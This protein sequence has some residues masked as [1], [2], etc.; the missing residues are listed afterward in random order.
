M[1]SHELALEAPTRVRPGVEAPLAPGLNGIRNW[2]SPPSRNHVKLNPMTEPQNHLKLV[3]PSTNLPDDAEFIP[4]PYY[5]WATRPAHLPL[6]VEEVATSLYLAQGIIGRAAER[7]KTEPLKVVRAIAGSARLRGLHKELRLFSTT[8][9]TRSMCGPSK[10]KTLVAVSGRRPRSLR[11]S[12][13][14][15]ILSRR[16]QCPGAACPRRPTSDADSD[17]LGGCARHRPRAQ[18]MTAKLGAH[19]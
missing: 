14:R 6:D 9:F 4:L 17:Q 7:L 19:D 12:R 15:R 3:D 11:R 16:T 18:P 10:T 2:E 13:S 8:R 1:R 5:P